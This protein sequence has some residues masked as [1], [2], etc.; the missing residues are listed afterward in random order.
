MERMGKSVGWIVAAGISL[1]YLAVLWKFATN[2]LYGDEFWT[3]KYTSA[4]VHGHLTPALFWEQWNESRM[5]V[6]RIFIS[7]SL[8]FDHYNTRHLVFLSGLLMVGAYLLV[9][10]L[11]SKWSRRPVGV[12]SALCIG[13]PWFSLAA[14]FTALW[15]FQL[16]WYLVVFFF[17]VMLWALDD[18][19]LSPSTGMAIGMAAAVLATLSSFQGVLC[20][21]VG[22]A[23]VIWKSP[24]SRQGWRRL[25][26]WGIAC[27]ATLGIYLVGYSFSDQTGLCPPGKSCTL[28][29]SLSNPLHLVKYWLNLTGL[30]FSGGGT[31]GQLVGAL[32]TIGALALL[33]QTVRQRKTRPRSPLPAALC[34][35]ALL[36]DIAITVGRVNYD[37]QSIADWYA[38][39][40]S[41]L[42]A[43]LAIAALGE[44][45]NKRSESPH[46]RA[47]MTVPAAL[48][49]L[50]VLVAPLV[51]VPDD[52]K[53]GQRW[54]D[55]QDRVARLAVNIVEQ[56]KRFRIC[57]E[58]IIF[59]GG[60]GTRTS[61]QYYEAIIASLRRDHL[62]MFAPGS[63]ET[64]RKKGLPTLTC[65][66]F[67]NSFYK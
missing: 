16:E 1:S 35:F 18:D 10:T 30:G 53:I 57:N 2:S 3:E 48:L 44:L 45:R 62:V 13:I 37:H 27:V 20:W 41:I 19:R 40:Q 66:Y 29:A 42:Y 15:A 55:S 4:A 65:R 60:L 59:Q 32:V 21:V 49:L 47:T 11:E 7:A 8:I 12:A 5:V 46:R 64:N 38:L 52:L 23:L 36:W 33:I 6:S 9:L 14:I 26:A 25:S 50:L 34:A 39:P 28:G 63:F 43:S 31:R 17:V 58:S 61:S 67:P 56:P 51:S 24:I 22:A 54:K